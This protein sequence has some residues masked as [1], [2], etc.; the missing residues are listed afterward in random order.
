MFM[1]ATCTIAYFAHVAF[2]LEYYLLA[3]F[4]F[5]VSIIPSYILYMLKNSFFQPLVACK[6]GLKHPTFQTYKYKGFIPWNDISDI[7]CGK[8]ASNYIVINLKRDKASERSL[9]HSL[10]TG[11]S[12]SYLQLNVSVFYESSFDIAKKLNDA[13]FGRI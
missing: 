6:S 11:F 5:V 4:L 8:L 3:I 10:F 2:L 1:F 7:D 9:K 13:K 12:N